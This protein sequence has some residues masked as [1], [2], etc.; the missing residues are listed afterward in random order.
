MPNAARVRLA[1]A[2]RGQAAHRGGNKSSRPYGAAEDLLRDYRGA[3]QQ[4]VDKAQN[5]E[6]EMT[7]AA[8]IIRG[9][10]RPHLLVLAFTR[11]AH[12]CHMFAHDFW[13]TQPQEQLE[14]DIA[15]QQ[16]IELADSGDQVK[17]KGGR[18]KQQEQADERHQLRQ[19]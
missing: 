3:E 10:P 11:G 14:G 16:P 18:R 17:L 13:W 4:A 6:K 5:G 1:K 15:D 7:R 12:L 8:R 9:I 19:G 2:R